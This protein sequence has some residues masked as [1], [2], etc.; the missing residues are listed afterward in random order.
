MVE[1]PR[2]LDVAGWLAH[3]ARTGEDLHVILD[4]EDVTR[5]CFRVVFHRDSYVI[6]DV[7]LYRLTD[8]GHRYLDPTTGKCATE[9]RTGEVSIAPGAPL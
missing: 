1:S 3:Q 5:R 7:W 2:S 4:G 6:A 9:M 8:A